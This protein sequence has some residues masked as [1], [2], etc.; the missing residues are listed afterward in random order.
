MESTELNTDNMC[1]IAVSFRAQPN[2]EFFEVIYNKWHVHRVKLS[3]HMGY[4]ASIPSHYCPPQR[5]KV[6]PLP[7]LPL[8]HEFVQQT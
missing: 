1:K 2:H 6:Q 8:L 4:K 3:Q 5:D 7:I